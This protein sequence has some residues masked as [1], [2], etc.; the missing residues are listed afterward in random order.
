MKM[1]NTFHVSVPQELE[2]FL[3]KRVKEKNYRSRGSY[4]QE[5]IRQDQMRA[6]KV[7]L[8]NM[9]LMGLAS[10]REKMTKK[11]WDAL[12]DET[13]SQISKNK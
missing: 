5:L 6:E 12:R 9:L 1:T 13:A 7:K 10:E 11:K 4:V 2:Q 3:E 8:T